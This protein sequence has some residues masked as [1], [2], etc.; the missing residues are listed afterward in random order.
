MAIHQGHMRRLGTML[1][2]AALLALAGC[3]GLGPPGARPPPPA[4]PQA[5]QCLQYLAAAG[6][7][8]ERLT[9]FRTPQ[10][11]G[12]AGAVRVHRAAIAWSRPAMASCA[13]AARLY[14]FERGVVQP[15]ATR[16]F[17]QPVQRIHHLGTYACRNERGGRRLSQ[18]ALGQ[19]VDITAF[20]LA[21]GNLV[22]VAR[23]WRGGGAAAGFLHEVAR[24]ACGSFSVVLTPNSDA[25]H[26]DHFHLD[27]GPHT[28][29]GY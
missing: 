28:L 25:A 10:G 12:I 6:V 23:H 4:V 14:E 1:S 17:G 15:L 18:H 22:S 3:S 9:D 8:F 11:C 13:L 27:I 24:R 29:C 5:G 21:D 26:H 19:A 16:Y 20:E 7:A 2:M